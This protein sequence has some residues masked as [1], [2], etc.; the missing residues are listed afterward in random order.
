[1]TKVIN[2][3]TLKC[4]FLYKRKQVYS[5]YRLKKFVDPAKSNFLNETERQKNCSDANKM[6][7]KS[8]H[9]AID[10]FNN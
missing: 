4:K 5:A 2:G 6:S 3:Q 10:A 8:L 7:L 1:V 9:Q